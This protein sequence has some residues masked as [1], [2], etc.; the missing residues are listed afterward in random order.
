[1]KKIFC[2]LCVL[3]MM[4]AVTSC[5]EILSENSKKILF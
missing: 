1:M 4:F 3:I 5:D 2:V